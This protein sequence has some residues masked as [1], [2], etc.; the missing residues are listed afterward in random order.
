MP[1]SWLA[2]SDSSNIGLNKLSIRS[3]FGAIRLTFR[4]IGRLS[5][6]SEAAVRN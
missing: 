3:F 4:Q 1:R 2:V 5:E 6:D